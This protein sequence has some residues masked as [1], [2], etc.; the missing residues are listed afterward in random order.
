[1][2]VPVGRCLGCFHDFTT[3]P[4]GGC[5]AVDDGT[6]AGRAV[7]TRHLFDGLT[8]DIRDGIEKSVAYCS[9]GWSSLGPHGPE[10][11]WRAPIQ[12]WGEHFAT[13]IDKSSLGPPLPRAPRCMKCG[14][15]QTDPKASRHT[16]GCPNVAMSPE[17][18]DRL[19]EYLSRP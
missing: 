13:E 8:L 18:Q 1:M 2:T 7:V 9:C 12:R 14:L 19:M 6:L 16:L 5:G 15:E 17:A 4:C 10:T 11:Q 3:G